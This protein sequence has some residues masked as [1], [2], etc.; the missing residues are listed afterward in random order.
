MDEDGL[1]NNKKEFINID[2]S[3]GRPDGMAV[4]KNGIL[5]VAVF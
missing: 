1:L 5:C 2:V 3:D 4:D